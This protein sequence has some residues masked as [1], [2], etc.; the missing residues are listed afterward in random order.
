MKIDKLVVGLLIGAA[1]FTAA[2]DDAVSAPVLSAADDETPDE[3]DTRADTW[4]AV[5]ELGREVASSDAGID[6]TEVD[7]NTTV[8]MFYYIWH[9]Q[10]SDSG[11]DISVLLQENPDNPAWGS[12]N[13]M[14]WGSKPWLGYYRAGD[15]YIVAK[16]IQMLTD[17]GVDFL[18]FDCTNANVYIN[19]VQVVLDELQRR[20]DLGLRYPKL[21]FM[22]H[23]NPSSTLGT[24]FNRFYRN[25][26]QNDKFWFYYDG[27]PLALAPPDEISNTNVKGYFTFR[28]SWAWMRG[29]N[30][31]EWAWLEYYPQAPGWANKYDPVALMTRKMNEQISVSVAQH[32][33]TKVGKSYH[34]DRQPSIDKY[35]MCK[36]T[37]QGLYFQEQWN[38]AIDLHVPLVMVTQFNEWIAQRFVITDQSQYGDVRPGAT[39]KI[40]ET[41]FVDVYSPEFSRDLEPSS[42]P[43][44][45]DNYYMQLISNVRRYRG[46]HDIPV[47]TRSLTISVQG[48]FSQWDEETVEYRDDKADTYYTSEAVQTPETLDR[49]TND[50]VRAKVTKNADTFFFY[51]E[52]MEE[53]TPFETSDRWMH[54]LINADCDYS[55]GWNGYDYMVA[56]DAATGQY[57]LMRN[58]AAGKYEWTAVEPV[59]WRTEGN[60]LQLAIDRALIGHAGAEKDFDFKWTDNI[61]DN[62]PD[63]LSFISDGDVAPN[64]RFNYR[65]KGSKLQGVGALDGVSAGAPSH[66]VVTVEGGCVKVSVDDADSPFAVTVADM[67]GRSVASA[68]NAAGEAV[69]LPLVPGI[70]VVRWCTDSDAGSVK[71]I[72]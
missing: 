50:I 1:G 26:P 57:S 22:V 3:W 37:P 55:N 64:A 54:L 63:I 65:Y 17:A 20:H 51:V 61:S 52:T 9:G 8:G 44:V 43:S 66:G 24:A 41:Y 56:K 21:A 62:N 33:T 10:H 18:F 29:K 19:Q 58:A 72:L 36:E 23:S 39:A 38:R 70:Y 67:L 35:G 45:R 30:P 49:K 40:G 68:Q 6:R 48:D 69:T 16:H 31:E 53:L 13:S 42:H 25:K 71:V 7:A 15:P 11:K 14:H 46:A 28:N 4:V 12:V 60:R 59:A 5:D 27:K 32:A 2:A 34:N 47:P